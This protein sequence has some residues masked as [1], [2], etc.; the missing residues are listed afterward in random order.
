LVEFGL[1]LLDP[2]LSRAITPLSRMLR[3]SKSPGGTRR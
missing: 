2:G 3:L 1:R